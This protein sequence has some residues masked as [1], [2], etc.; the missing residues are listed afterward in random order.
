[1]VFTDE[2][3]KYIEEY[4]AKFHPLTEKEKI[5]ILK[6]AKETNTEETIKKLNEFFS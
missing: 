4:E 2:E 6:I 1:M 3:K 5:Y